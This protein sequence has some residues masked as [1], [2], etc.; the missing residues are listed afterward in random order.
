MSHADLVARIRQRA[1]EAREEKERELATRQ[2]HSKTLDTT[3]LKQ[4]LTTTDDLQTAENVFGGI[5]FNDK[6]MQAVN[7]AKEGNP[8]CLIGAAGTGKTTTVKAIVHVLL[9]RIA[10]EKDLPVDKLRMDTLL[11]GSFTNR[12]VKNIAKAVGDVPTAKRYCSTIHKF[13]AFAPVDVKVDDGEGGFKTSMRFMPQYTKENPIDNCVLVIVEEASMVSVDLFKMLLDACPNAIFIFLGDLNQLPPVFGDAILGFKLM[14]LPVVELTE[15]YRQ[16]MDSPIVAFQHNFTLKGFLPG[17]TQLEDIQTKSNG[18]LSFTPLKNERKYEG[19]QLAKAIGGVMAKKYEAGTYDPSDSIILIPFNKSF[20]TIE[21]NKQLAQFFSEKVNRQ[22]VYEII[23]GLETVYFAP[24]DFVVWNKEEYVIDRIE[25]ND[26]YTGNN[27]PRHESL[28]LNRDGLDPNDD[29]LGSHMMDVL[30]QEAE[31]NR[32]DLDMLLRTTDG[33]LKEDLEEL[34]A[35]ASHVIYLTSPDWVSPEERVQV[36]L[37]TRGELNTLEFGY[38][39]TVHKSQGSEWRRVYFILTNKHGV[40]LSRELIYTG[41]TRAKEELHMFY[42]P[43]SAVGRKNSSICKAI[44]N[45]TIKGNTLQ[46]KI[47]HFVG[48][49]D[50]YEAKMND[51][52]E[53]AENE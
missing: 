11:L 49:K 10:K 9:K 5:T 35:Q 12:A 36:R 28:T 27:I 26:K 52:Y 19:E 2:Q 40:M 39:I 42:T 47:R 15:V 50:T 24:G 23:A 20:G 53:D 29:G 38:A 1:K 4:G 33:D 41:M 48:K 3:Y 6:Q 14:E 22:P 46:E 31:V 8:F 44:K 13:L 37:N 21:I 25:R 17:Q 34:K 32:T 18:K 7:L 45:Q 43:Q 30:E 16:A 51:D